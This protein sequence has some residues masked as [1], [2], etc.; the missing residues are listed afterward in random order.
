MFKQCELTKPMDGGI[1]SMISWIPER[2]AVAQNI[3]SLKD[4]ESGEQTDGWRVEYVA[5]A[6]LPISVLMRQFVRDH[7]KTLEM[8]PTKLAACQVKSRSSVACGF[9][10]GSSLSKL[11][12]FLSI[13]VGPPPRSRAKA[14][15]PRRAGLSPRAAS[16]RHSAG[17][18]L[19]R[20][21][22]GLKHRRHRFDSCPA[23]FGPRPK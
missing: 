21:S 6:S 9:G 16:W 7:L 1:A 23:H 18:Q 3:V 12:V 11:R 2:L 10:S 8:P 22:G 20:S 19:G 4:S 13:L 5:Q 17:W 15:A 14:A